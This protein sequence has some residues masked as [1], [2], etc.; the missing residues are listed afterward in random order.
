[1]KKINVTVF[2]D[3]IAK[4]LLLKNGRPTYL[5]TSAVEIVAD[6]FGL[7][8]DNKSTFG[9]TITRFTEK[10]LV[11]EYLSSLRKKDRNIVVFCIGGNDS[12]YDWKAIDAAPEKLHT[13]KTPLDKFSKLY[14]SAIEKLKKKKVKVYICALPVVHVK[15]FF[16]NY[17][18]SLA[19][20]ENIMKFLENDTSI[21]ARQQEVFNNRLREIAHETKTTF[22]DIRTPFLNVKNLEKVYADD[23]LHPNEAGQ[24]LIAETIINF[25]ENQNN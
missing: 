1:M 17:V 14:L 24:K 3:S 4:G 23:G 15:S 5:K 7:K 25:F 21:I 10:K 13:C 6:H 22:L 8:I 2:G 11:E 12:D 9:Q 19:N 16:Q 20:C 18:C